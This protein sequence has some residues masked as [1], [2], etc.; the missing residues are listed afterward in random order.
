MILIIFVEEPNKFLNNIPEP[1]LLKYIS[2][3]CH[4]IYY[5]NLIVLLLY[6]F[7]ETLNIINLI[8]IHYYHYKL[9]KTNNFYFSFHIVFLNYKTVE[10]TYL[11]NWVK[12]KKRGRINCNI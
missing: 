11:N 4:V 6:E 8:I 2:H 3:K 5:I 1:S 7:C 10:Y 12:I 9:K